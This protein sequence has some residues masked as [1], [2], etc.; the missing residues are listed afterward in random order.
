[1]VGGVTVTVT[2]AWPSPGTAVGVPGVPGA[3]TVG[4]VSSTDTVPSLVPLPTLVT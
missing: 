3:V 4:A 2:V 1:V